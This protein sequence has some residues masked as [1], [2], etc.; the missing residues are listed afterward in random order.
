MKISHNIIKKIFSEKLK[1]KNKMDKIELSQYTEYIPMY[2]IYSD[3]IYPIQNINLHYR[4]ITCHYRFITEEIKQWLINKMNKE[5]NLIK[6]QKYIDNISI[7]DNYDLSIL[8]KTSYE[9]LY[10]YSPDLGLSISI[11]KRNSFSPF[12]SHLTPYYTKIE[13]IKLGMNNKTIKMKNNINPI[14]LMDNS[15]HYK[16]CKKVSKNDISSE[17]ISEHMKAIISNK[18]IGWIVYYSLTGSYILNKILREN[19][20]ITRY[21]YDGL[22]LI[23]S[24]MNTVSLPRDYYFYRFIWDDSYIKDMKIGNVFIDKGFISTTRDPFYSPGIKMDFGLILIRINVPKSIKGSGLLIE[25]F[26]LFPKEEEYLIQPSTKL[27]LVARD[28]NTSYYHTNEKFERL[29]K[30][31]YEFTVVSIDNNILD[32]IKVIE[33]NNIQSIDLDNV[34]ININISNNNI[35]TISNTRTDLFN[36]FLN[37]CDNMGMYNYNDMIFTAQWFDSLSSYQSL[38]YNKTKDGMIHTCYTKGNILISIECGEKIVINYMKTK[39]YYDMIHSIDTIDMITA[40]YCK[41][42]NYMEAYIFFTYKNFSEFSSNYSD[43]IEFLYNEMYCD[44][45]YLYIKNKI[46][47]TNKY[48]KYEYGFWKIDSIIKMKVPLE[49]LN[50]LPT[51]LQN[52]DKL[53][54]GQLFIEIVEK[55]FYLYKKMETWFNTY[56]DNIFKY[57]YY[58]FNAIGFLKSNGYN[59]SSIPNFKH[60][61]MIDRGDIFQLVYRMTERRT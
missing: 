1:L 45:I 52:I 51:T 15:S 7:I 19:L 37:K 11:C 3:N 47:M 38:Y 26:S 43:N 41:L 48:Y 4:L 40:M 25:N 44:T 29:I 60:V 58:T 6:K 24:T 30:K 36:N 27:K 42:F 14:N 34:N 39:C 50:K 54:W 55:Y 16:I 56:H 57:N 33:D 53:T 18:C 10:R 23:I 32:K 35:N 21:M 5:T 28:L 12:S 61:N 31:K 17:T 8:E 13:L 59:I 46:K 22:K 20:P 9:T 2:D 49:I